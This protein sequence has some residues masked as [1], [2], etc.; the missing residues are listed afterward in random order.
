[1]RSSQGFAMPNF[2]QK[3]LHPDWY[4]GHG[5]QP[6][7]FEGW[8]FKLIDATER[9]RYAVIPGIF[10][11]RDR[12]KHHAFVQVLDGQTGGSAARNACSASSSA[13]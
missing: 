6:P 7:F 3:V 1:M 12:E 10:L 5:K 2:F 9:Y 11:S 8:Y 4:H 13:A